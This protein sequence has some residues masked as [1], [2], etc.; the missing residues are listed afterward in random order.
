M[1]DEDPEPNGQKSTG[2]SQTSDC[3]S[4]ADE[5]SS[6]EQSTE[7]SSDWI[8]ETELDELVE[9]SADKEALQVV[10]EE[11]REV[12]SERIHLLSDIDDKAMRT[13]RTSVLFIGLVISAVQVS[14]GSFSTVSA[15]SMSFQI[16]V[17]GVSFLV[18]SII[19]GVYTYSASEPDLGISDDHRTDVV[20]GEFTEREWLLFQLGEYNEW[21][22][23]MQ[24]LTKKNVIW[25]HLT[26]FTATAGVVALLISVVYSVGWEFAPLIRPAFA[27]IIISLIIA[28]IL[29][30]VSSPN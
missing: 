22:G 13:V 12:L 25:L 28:L 9:Y 7:I 30:F 29:Y 6:D 23:N 1:A 18:L 5:G 8:Q 16:G 11:S 2:T 26:L 10:R 19:L 14:N 3:N 21:T 20:E 17:A 4:T 27:A 15:D 24:S